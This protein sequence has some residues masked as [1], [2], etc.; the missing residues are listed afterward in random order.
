MLVTDFDCRF[1]QVLKDIEARARERNQRAVELMAWAHINTTV[2]HQRN[3]EGLCKQWD[4]GGRKMEKMEE[5]D[6]PKLIQKTGSFDTMN[7]DS[8][9]NLDCMVQ[10]QDAAAK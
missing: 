3:A 1:E 7:T 6:I 9:F 5:N 4:N 10:M 8:E 2:L